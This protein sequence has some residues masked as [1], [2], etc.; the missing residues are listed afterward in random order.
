MFA[1]LCVLRFNALLHM[2][3][4][5][6]A[7]LV[8]PVCLKVAAHAS[9]VCPRLPAAWSEEQ[10]E[11]QALFRLKHWAERGHGL[12]GELLSFI[13]LYRA[14]TRH[15]MSFIPR[16]QLPQMIYDT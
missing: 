7:G 3:S 15:V 1:A 6:V 14:A 10:Q 12:A 8:Y 11:P 4:T 2:L 9:S 13:Q 5:Q 16:P